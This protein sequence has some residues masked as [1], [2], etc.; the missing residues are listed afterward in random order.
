MSEQDENLR[1]DLDAAAF[2]RLLAH[3]AA[4]PEV[5]NIE[6]MN[7]AG[8]CRN[9]LANWRQEAAAERGISMTKDEARAEIYGMPYEVWRKLHQREASPEAQAAFAARE[10]PPS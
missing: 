4:H 3:L 6:M 10:K 8:F 1:R 2:R 9:C 7:L 5:Q